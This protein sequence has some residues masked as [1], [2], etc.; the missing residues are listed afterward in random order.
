VWPD[1]MVRPVPE[2]MPR[3]WRA[4]LLC[5]ASVA[6]ASSVRWKGRTGSGAPVVVKGQNQQGVVGQP[7]FVF[8]AHPPNPSHP[9]MP[10]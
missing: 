7:L 1:G 3:T 5:S 9:C 8:E 4:H 2:M 10:P 6:C